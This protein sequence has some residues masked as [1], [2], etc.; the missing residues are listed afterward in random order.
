MTSSPDKEDLWAVREE[1]IRSYSTL[2]A[3]P[4]PIERA[5]NKECMSLTPGLVLFGYESEWDMREFE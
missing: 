5:I 3:P 2:P 1:C 4:G